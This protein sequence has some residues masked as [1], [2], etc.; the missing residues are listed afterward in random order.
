MQMEL[1]WTILLMDLTEEN[2]SVFLQNS[3]KNYKI[4]LSTNYTVV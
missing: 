1:F 4:L 3:I 2:E